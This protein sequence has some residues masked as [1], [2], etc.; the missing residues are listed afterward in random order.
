MLRKFVDGLAFGAGFSVAFIALWMIVT[1]VIYPVYLESQMSDFAGTE[2]VFPDDNDDTSLIV[3]PAYGGE[4]F[5][6]LSIEE[7]IA[8]SSA[9]ALAK[10]QPADDGRM[11]AVIVEYLKL[12]PG[13]EIRYSV[14]DE[15]RSSSYYPN[16]DRIRGDGEV[17]FFTG[18][19]ASMELSTS[20]YGDRVTGLNDIPLALF[21]EKCSESAAQ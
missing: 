13:T 1:I 12:E 18:S 4:P 9:I 21:R 20:V 17:I 6:S 15:Y 7:Q 10:F 19:P 16:S 11:Q 2:I 14:G 8:N 3:H 5:Y